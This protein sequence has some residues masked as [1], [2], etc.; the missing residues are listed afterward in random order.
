[1]VLIRAE[2]NVECSHWR[3]TVL[4][5]IFTT[6]FCYCLN[7]NFRF[8]SWLA[9]KFRVTLISNNIIPLFYGWCFGLAFKNTASL[10]AASVATSRA[11]ITATL[12][13]C[14]GSGD[15]TI[16]QL[17]PKTNMTFTRNLLYSR[18]SLLNKYSRNVN[19][20]AIRLQNVHQV[21]TEK[22]ICIVG[23]GPAG[24][25]AAQYLLKQ[26]SDCTVDIVEKLPVPFGLVR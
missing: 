14:F 8:D 3:C 22:R 17:F 23:A 25:Y 21:T 7:I 20:S 16:T 19:T 24:F 4:Y 12:S 11:C 26:L 13:L 18:L 15:F 10:L 6:L 9:N 5:C 1:M 2:C